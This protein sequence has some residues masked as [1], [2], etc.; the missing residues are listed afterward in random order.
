M[1]QGGARTMQWWA[2]WSN[3]TATAADSSALGLF[4]GA[5]QQ[6]MLKNQQH[7]YDPTSTTASASI[8]GQATPD[9]SPE[10]SS[11]RDPSSRHPTLTMPVTPRDG[12][13][14]APSVCALVDQQQHGQET[15]RLMTIL[16]MVAAA[17][18]RSRVT[19]TARSM[20]RRTCD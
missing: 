6:R 15:M 5:T 13:S 14:P 11:Q 18:S 10:S 12:L 2:T 20:G 16:T 8:S 19:H 17:V 1:P 7:K 4:A 9:S 3:F